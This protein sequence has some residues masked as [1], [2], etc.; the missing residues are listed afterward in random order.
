MFVLRHDKQMYMDHLCNL[1]KIMFALFILLSDK[2]GAEK[3][4]GKKCLI[5]ILLFHTFLNFT[6]T[7]AFFLCHCIL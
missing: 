7:N 1:Y 6:F 5:I 2:P 3:Q 4:L